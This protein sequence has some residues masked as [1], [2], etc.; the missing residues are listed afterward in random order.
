MAIQLP[1]ALAMTECLMTVDC[2]YYARL[3]PTALLTVKEGVHT[4]EKLLFLSL[5]QLQKEI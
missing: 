2:I 3:S 1:L 5:L 4:G